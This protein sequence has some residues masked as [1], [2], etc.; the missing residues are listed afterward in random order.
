M[1]R[2]GQNT[3]KV[4]HD[5]GSSFDCTRDPKKL[6]FKEETMRDAGGGGK[7]FF[8]GDKIKPKNVMSNADRVRLGL[9]PD[10]GQVA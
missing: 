5:D 4:H 8:S 3:F 6:R 1:E 2:T 7:F 9:E 10:P